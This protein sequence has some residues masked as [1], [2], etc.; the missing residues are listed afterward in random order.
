[1]SPNLTDHRN[2]LPHIR[3]QERLA[4]NGYVFTSDTT[5]KSFRIVQYYLDAGFDSESAFKQAIDEL[6][7]SYAVTAMVTGQ[8]VL[9]ASRAPHLVGMEDGESRATSRPLEDTDGL[10]DR[11]RR[12]HHR[13]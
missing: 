9:Y 4:E 7:G 3:T 5:P 2:C 10:P 13:R 12:R 8:H 11:R 1:M 6:E